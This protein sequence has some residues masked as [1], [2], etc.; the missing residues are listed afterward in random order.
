MISHHI[1]L[2]CI[3]LT[4]ASVLNRGQSETSPSSVTLVNNNHLILPS[5]GQNASLQHSSITHECRDGYYGIGAH[6]ESCEEALRTM[7][8]VPVPAR[9]RQLT[10]GQRNTGNYD[11]PL[12]QRWVS[13]EWLHGVNHDDDLGAANLLIPPSGRI[14]L[15]RNGNNRRTPVRSREPVG[16]DGRRQ[17]CRKQLRTPPEGPHGRDR[18][19]YQW[20]SLRLI[21]S[22]SAT[23][24]CSYQMV[25]T[26]SA[27]AS[28]RRI[29]QQDARRLRRGSRRL[30]AETSLIVWIPGRE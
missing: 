6:A 12:P 24:E 22:S 10:W 5:F 14:L 30:R 18:G 15:R 4:S 2:L 28:S 16:R 19:A 9:R 29:A 11:I 17:S 21:K 23:S 20:V 7:A 1:A 26:L 3:S 25:K 8:I 13:C 27:L